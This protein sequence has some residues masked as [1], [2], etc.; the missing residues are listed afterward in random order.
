MKLT[1]KEI[2]LAVFL[3]LPLCSLAQE[4]PAGGKG[5]RFQDDL[6]WAA[7][8]A[9]ARAENKYI[10]V[11]GFTTWCGPCK[12]MK[13]SVFPQQESGDYF[14]SKFISV[15]V[16]LDTTKG[17]NAFVRSWYKDAH[18][19]MEDYHIRA[20]PTFL[21]FTPDGRVVHRMV[22]SS[23]TA[24]E[25]IAR[26]SQSFDPEKQY[27]T[28][29]K[30]Y[31]EGQRDSSFLRRMAIM[32]RDAYDMKN[33]EAIAKAYFATQKDLFNPGT[34]ALL[35]DFTTSTKDEG[36]DVFYHHA[37]E[38]DKVLGQGTA[39][40]KVR[41]I[42]VREYVYAKVLGKNAPVVPDWNA[43]AVPLAAKYPQEAAEVL[44]MGKVAYYQSKNDWNHFQV[45]VV[46]YMKKYGTEANVQQ[47]N[48][49]AWTVFQHCPDMNCVTEALDWS[50]RSFKDNHEPAFMDTYANILY[51]M[52]KKEDAIAWEEKARDLSSGDGKKGFQDTIEKMKKGEKT[53]D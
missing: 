29:L 47:L 17:D 37:A 7:V 34:L 24:K 53:W 4:K 5:V 1:I 43:V 15:G 19:L 10:F 48:S 52:G 20:F 31:K 23:T 21:I 2:R 6:S 40:K 30:K 18:A 27:Y 25:F 9:K 49:Y 13:N 3:L 39:E 8:K 22:G 11:D 16:Q 33:A 26:V 14:N 42:L 41:D 32:A 50:K 45:V 35:N 28:Q 44:S 38:V 12:Y 46:D 36:F 51:K